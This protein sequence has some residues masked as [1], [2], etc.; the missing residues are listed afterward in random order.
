MDK[1]ITEKRTTSHPRNLSRTA[2]H[3]DTVHQFFRCHPGWDAFSSKRLY[4]VK[5][6]ITI[7]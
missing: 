6:K 7:F 4:P 3:T 5:T 2:F 1:I